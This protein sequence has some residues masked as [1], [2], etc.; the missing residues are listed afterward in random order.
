MAR[1]PGFTVTWV[2]SATLLVTAT[3]T[4]TCPPAGKDPLDGETVTLPAMAAG[5]RT[6]YL[7]TGPPVAVST[8]IPLAVFPLTAVSTSLPGAAS[9]WPWAGE[10]EGEADGERDG[11]DG[12]CDGE[13]GGFSLG[14]TGEGAGLVAPA[15]TVGD[16]VAGLAGGAALCAGDD[17]GLAPPGLAPPGLAPPRLAPP[18]LALPRFAP[19]GLAPS[20]LALPG[21]ALGEVPATPAPSPRAEA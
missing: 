18:G 5:T 4:A 11:G 14:A 17:A 16:G 2:L 6:L 10:V 20:R 19:P 15:G 21:M 7:L 3:V 13:A 1:L 9:R 12:V 8:K